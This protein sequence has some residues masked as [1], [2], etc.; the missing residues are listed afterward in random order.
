MRPRVG[1][2]SALKP[3]VL[4]E[5]TVIGVE[6]RGSGMGLNKHEKPGRRVL[7]GGVGGN[8]YAQ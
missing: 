8:E 7:P 2:F 6:P 4:V 1:A 3:A 5:D